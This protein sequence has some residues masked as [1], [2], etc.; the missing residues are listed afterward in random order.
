ML[1]LVVGCTV[2]ACG[3]LPLTS[4]RMPLIHPPSPPF[5]S[6][7]SPPPSFRVPVMVLHVF[8]VVLVTHHHQ[9]LCKCVLDLAGEKKKKSFSFSVLIC[10]QAVGTHSSRR[11]IWG[12]D[13]LLLIRREKNLVVFFLYSS[14]NIFTPAGNITCF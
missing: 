8:I 4:A 11:G 10:W 3:S 6:S 2:R 14:S 13:L 1:V 12:P 7:S 5:P 9:V